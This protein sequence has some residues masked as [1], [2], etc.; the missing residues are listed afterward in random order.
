MVTVVCRLSQPFT[1]LKILKL[2]SYDEM[3]EAILSLDK[4][5]LDQILGSP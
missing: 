4:P 1:A 3:E 5:A 2:I